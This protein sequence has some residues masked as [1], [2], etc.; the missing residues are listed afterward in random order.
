MHPQRGL[1]DGGVFECEAGKPSGQIALIAFGREVRVDVLDHDD[2]EF[3]IALGDEE[4]GLV[5]EA[6]VLVVPV[7]QHDV[8]E[9]APLQFAE[10]VLDHAHEGGGTQRDRAREVLAAA[11]AGPAA[12]SEG[13]EGADDQTRRRPRLARIRSGRTQSV[14]TGRW[15]PCCSVA[16]IGITIGVSARAASSISSHVICWKTQERCVRH[17][18]TFV[19]SAASRDPHWG[20]YA[21]SSVVTGSR[22][23]ADGSEVS[24]PI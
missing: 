21:I 3:G 18:Q 17:G 6:A 24:G 11:A 2:L 14:Q 8:A 1:D 5:D 22:P 9:S 16:P 15:R 7:V 20:Q 13:Q 4:G 10:D 19:L 12:V 23:R